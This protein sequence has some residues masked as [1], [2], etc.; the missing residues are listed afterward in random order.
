[1]QVEFAMCVSGADKDLDSDYLN[2]RK[3]IEIG[4]GIWQGA[5]KEGDTK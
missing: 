5:G 3:K 1:M 2:E 4:D